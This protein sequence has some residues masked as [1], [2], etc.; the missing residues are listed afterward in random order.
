MPELVLDLELQLI[1]SNHFSWIFTFTKKGVY[2]LPESP[3]SRKYGFKNGYSSVV[4]LGTAVQFYLKH[5]DSL[6]FFLFKVT[7]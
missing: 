6:F 1:I 4:L 7:G 2:F 5:L 3:Q